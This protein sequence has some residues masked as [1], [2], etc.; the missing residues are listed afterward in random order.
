MVAELQDMLLVLNLARNDDR[1]QQEQISVAGK[2]FGSIVAW[3]VFR[4]EPGLKSCVLLTPL[5]MADKSGEDEL[6]LVRENYPDAGHEN[7]PVLMLAGNAD[8]HCELEI[9]R[10]FVVNTSAKFNINVLDGNHNLEMPDAD[11]AMAASKFDR[12]LQLL[13][14]HV[15]RF[16][17]G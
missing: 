6:N 12:N 2:S 5:C 8:P 13:A 4:E 3:R 17:L 7:R 14:S 1:V 10:Q 15:E 11:A 16:L 9:L